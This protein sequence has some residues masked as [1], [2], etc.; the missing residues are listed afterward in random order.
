MGRYPFGFDP[1][2]PPGLILCDQCG[3][4][5]I[6][7]VDIHDRGCGCPPHPWYR[8]P[9]PAK[10]FEIAARSGPRPPRS[11]W[12]DEHPE[13]HGWVRA[14]MIHIHSRVFKYWCD[15]CDQWRSWKE[16]DLG[17]IS[18]YRPVRAF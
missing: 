14:D 7:Y 1:V 3:N 4:R 5:E 12:G 16:S 10:W 17:A 11:E 6:G 8:Q 15:G 18:R 13:Y 2:H 9:P